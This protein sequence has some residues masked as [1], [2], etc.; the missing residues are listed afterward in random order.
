[1]HNKAVLSPLTQ[2]GPVSAGPNPV[3]FV[4]LGNLLLRHRQMN[5]Q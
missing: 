1:M 3:G 4:L 5:N 2:R